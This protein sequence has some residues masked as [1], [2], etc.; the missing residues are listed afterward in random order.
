ME[1]RDQGENPLDRKH[2]ML[3]RGDFDDN[4]ST[5]V[6]RVVCHA[7]ALKTLTH[8]AFFMVGRG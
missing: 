4:V 6:G 7:V 8:G 5:I 3:P 1:T 2:E